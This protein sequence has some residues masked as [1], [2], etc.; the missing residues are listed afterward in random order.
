M[1]Y[2]IIK[3]DLV[4][5]LSRRI[6]DWRENRLEKWRWLN[7]RAQDWSWNPSSPSGSPVRKSERVRVGNKFQPSPGMVTLRNSL[8]QLNEVLRFIFVDTSVGLLW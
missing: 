3:H 4:A 6:S 5:D 8:V 2:H 1:L 7:G